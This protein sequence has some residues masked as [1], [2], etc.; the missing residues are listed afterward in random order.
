[1][2]DRERQTES[3]IST[4]LKPPTDGSKATASKRQTEIESGREGQRTT[5]N[6]CQRAKESVIQKAAER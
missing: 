3:D 5:G 6:D 4:R 2:P 1:M